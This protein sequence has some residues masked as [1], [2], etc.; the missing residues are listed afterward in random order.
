VL[1]S[2]TVAVPAYNEAGSLRDVV[3]QLRARLPQVAQRYEILIINDGSRDRTGEIADQLAAEDPR[4]RVIHHPFNIGYGGGQKS[5]ILQSTCDYIMVVPADGQFNPDDLPRYVEAVDDFDI[6][7]GYRRYRKSDSVRRKLNT[8]VFRLVMA[9][10]FGIRLK[11][12]NWVKLIRRR[13]FK[14]MEITSRGICIDAELMF[15]A[16]LR[17]SSFKEIPV[18]YQPRK[19]GISTGDRPLNVIIT[20][21]ELLWLRISAWFKPELFR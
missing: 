6:V 12:T 4:I 9:G 5:A 16:K 20:V 21:L 14:G 8:F 18:D 7:V 15:K 17:G 2:L 11:D 13:I 1:S 3:T 19:S 10:F